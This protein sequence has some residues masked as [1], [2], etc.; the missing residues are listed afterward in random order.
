[1][2]FTL[3]GGLRLAVLQSTSACNL[4]C[5]YCYVPDRRQQGRMSEDVLRAAASFMFA[6]EEKDRSADRYVEFLWHAGEPLAA[7]IPFYARAFAIIASL[8]PSGVP[9]RHVMQ[10]NGTLVNIAWCEFFREY[11]VSIGL[12][13]D[14]PTEL[15]DSNRRTWGDHGS[16]GRVMRG[17]RLLREYGFNP[18]AICVLTQESLMQPDLIYDFFV[19]AGFTSIAFNVDEKEG[20]NATTSLS[21]EDFESVRQRYA[22]FMRRLWH[23]WRADDGRITIREFDHIL[24]C[25]HNLQV[26]PSFFREPDEVVPFGI[27]TVSRDGGISTFAPELAST[28]SKEYGDFLLGNVLSDTPDDVEKGQAFHRLARDVLVGRDLCKQTCQYYALCGGGFQS[29]R[30]AEHGSLR[31]TE[32]QTCKLHRQTLIDVIVDELIRETNAIRR[33]RMTRATAV[34]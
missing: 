13:I 21:Q 17:Y 9:V 20:A 3:R 15:H 31:A 8:A 28:T 1:M 2:T 4:N 22:A 33:G 10:T 18:S 16:H 29:N 32:T 30:I 7:G 23:R 25:I 27:I 5:T 26:D 14:G 34:V 6:R 11:G 19:G 12:S 24:A